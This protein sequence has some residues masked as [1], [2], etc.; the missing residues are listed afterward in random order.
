ML[1]AGRV[2]LLAADADLTA[3]PLAEACLQPTGLAVLLL[4]QLDAP[5]PLERSRLQLA[6]CQSCLAS[7][8]CN[9]QC[10]QS[11]GACSGLLFAAFARLSTCLATATCSK[12][13]AIGHRDRPQ[14]RAATCAAA[15]GVSAPVNGNKCLIAANARFK[16]HRCADDSLQLAKQSQDSQ[17][18]SMWGSH[19]SPCGTRLQLSRCICVPAAVSAQECLQI[20]QAGLACNRLGQADLV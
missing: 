19:S 13:W 6:S 4:Y 8:L 15:G 5:S 14:V 17:P 3:A 1:C 11:W 12:R 20:K 2:H 7:P 10:M 9:L 18:Q 16:T